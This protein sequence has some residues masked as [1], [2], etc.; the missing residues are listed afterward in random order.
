[1][2]EERDRYDRVIDRLLQDTQTRKQQK[3]QLMMT[4]ANSFQEFN[5]LEVL[6]ND[7]NT[8]RKRVYEAMLLQ[9]SPRQVL[10]TS[11]TIQNGVLTERGQQHSDTQ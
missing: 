9:K 2:P 6:R 5:Y 11:H 3:E 4:S 1:M 10:K 8:E 7:Q